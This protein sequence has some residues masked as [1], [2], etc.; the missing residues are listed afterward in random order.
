MPKKKG[1]KKRKKQSGIKGEER[2]D[3]R[4]RISVGKVFERERET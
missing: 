1:K 2:R 4:F 3:F